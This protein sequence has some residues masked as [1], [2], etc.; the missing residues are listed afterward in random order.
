[1]LPLSGASTV[2]R[3]PPV[4]FICLAFVLRSD[5]DAKSEKNALDGCPGIE[6]EG[7]SEAK[8]HGEI[9][10]DPWYSDRETVF[11]SKLR[12]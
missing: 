10:S 6:K 7:G 2:V 12:G 1:L 4:Q 11:V 9:P 8:G 3:S 5:H